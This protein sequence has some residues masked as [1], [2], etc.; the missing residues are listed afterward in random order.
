MAKGYLIG[1]RDVSLGSALVPP[2]FSLTAMVYTFDLYVN[3]GITPSDIL[4]SMVRRE[5]DTTPRLAS[6]LPGVL[7]VCIYFERKRQT[8]ESLTRLTAARGLAMFVYIMRDGKLTMSSVFVY[9]SPG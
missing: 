9:A 3:L 1:C 8:D 6:L 2:S 4:Q 5:T 7:G